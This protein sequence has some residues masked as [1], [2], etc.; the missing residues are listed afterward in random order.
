MTKGQEKLL[1]IL[2]SRIGTPY[3][4]GGFDCSFF[5]LK[6][7]EELK[8]SGLLNCELNNENNRIRSAVWQA[9]RLGKE[10]PL[11]EKLKVGDLLFFEGNKGH[12][13]HSLFNGR[14][15]Y[16]GHVAI[17]SGNNKAIHAAGGKGAVEETLE[18]IVKER[19]PIVMIKRVLEDA[20]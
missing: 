11:E 7:L 4:Y 2:R 19:D 17:Y 8:E 3:E 10:I 13:D 6:S 16:I 18:E 15:L 9:A 5:A 12:Y 14:K 20:E 1:E